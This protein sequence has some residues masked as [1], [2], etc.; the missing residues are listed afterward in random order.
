MSV[1]VVCVALVVVPL[2]LIPAFVFVGKLCAWATTHNRLT[3]AA[4]RH[5]SSVRVLRITAH[6][7]SSCC[8]VDVALGGAATRVAC[9]VVGNVGPVRPAVIV[10]VGAFVG[11]R[12]VGLILGG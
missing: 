1:S 4:A 3:M 7:V 8:C 11:G 6:R 2:L 9:V 5:D 10:V 12:L